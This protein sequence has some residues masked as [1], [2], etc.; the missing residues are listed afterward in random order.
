MTAIRVQDGVS[1]FFTTV[2]DELHL[3]T[4][5]EDEQEI[6]DR[7]YWVTKGSKATVEL[8]DK[9]LESI[10]KFAP[11]YELNY[12]KYYIGLKKDGVSQ[13]FVSFVPR[14]RT[15]LLS[16][17]HEQTEEI[18][19]ILEDSDFDLLAYDHQWKQYRL[20]LTKKDLEKHEGPL[21]KLAE[22]AFNTYMK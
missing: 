6:V 10:S 3:G 21:T 16:L 14:K 13:N 4:E 7:K 2:I 11:D 22:L 9:I 20:R 1:L 18:D 5:E 19:V 15:M 8:A 12:N 17:K